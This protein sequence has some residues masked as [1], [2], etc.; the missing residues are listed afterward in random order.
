MRLSA[1]D[2]HSSGCGT[3]QLN[4]TGS[5]TGTVHSSGTVLPEEVGEN[6]SNSW[7]FLDQSHTSRRLH[8]HCENISLNT[9]LLKKIKCCPRR[10]GNHDAK[11]L[12]L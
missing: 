9:N 2:V 5:Y 7:E 11:Y 10:G 4:S 12:Y 1:A 3:L 6:L 8:I